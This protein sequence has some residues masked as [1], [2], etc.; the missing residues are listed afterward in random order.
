MTDTTQTPKMISTEPEVSVEYISEDTQ[1]ENNK[2]NVL[3]NL[4]GVIKG[5]IAKLEQLQ[6]EMRQQKEMLEDVLNNDPTYKL[7]S[8]AVKEANKIKSATKQQIMKQAQAALIASKIKEMKEE[9]NTMHIALPEYLQ[10]YQQ[11]SGVNEIE[12]NDGEMREIVYSAKLVKK[13]KKSS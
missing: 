12:G 2:M 4:E 13:A 9:M 6:N 11:L 8:D 7:H 3:M 5:Y 10:Q 1:A